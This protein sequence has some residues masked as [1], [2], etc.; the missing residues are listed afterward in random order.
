MPTIIMPVRLLWKSV[1]ARRICYVDA[2]VRQIGL[3]E[4]CFVLLMT[5]H[6]I[7]HRWNPGKYYSSAV[8][9]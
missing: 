5:S 9:D 7:Y 2:L 6:N 8:V 4:A 3:Q 1:F